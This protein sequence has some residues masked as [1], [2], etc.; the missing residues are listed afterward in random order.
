MPVAL[1]SPCLPEKSPSYKNKIYF[2]SNTAQI[3]INNARV[4]LLL[5]SIGSYPRGHS[6]IKKNQITN[7]QSFAAEKCQETTSITVE[8]KFL[9][10]AKK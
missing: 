8:D 10:E 1:G 9:S 3:E 4:N 6:E 5:R 2:K 7:E